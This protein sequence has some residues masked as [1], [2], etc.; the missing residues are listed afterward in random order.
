MLSPS[1]LYS[2]APN[3]TASTMLVT[4][5]FA[6]LW[7]IYKDFRGRDWLRIARRVVAVNARQWRGRLSRG[8]PAANPADEMSIGLVRPPQHLM[9]EGDW[10]SHHIGVRAVDSGDKPRGTA[11]D[12]V[13][14]GLVN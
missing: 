10:Q 6:A 12:R 11:L 4:P 2:R 14:S 1:V 8:H 13:G 7:L 5:I 9:N 3:V